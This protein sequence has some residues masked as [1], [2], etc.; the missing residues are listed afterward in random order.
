MIPILS[1]EWVVSFT[2]RLT[3]TSVPGKQYCSILHLTELGDGKNDEYNYRIPMVFLKGEPFFQVSFGSNINSKIEY[4]AKSLP[5]MNQP[6]HYEIH[7]R[8]ISGGKYKYFIMQNGEEI[9]SIINSNT[10]QFYNV[11]AYVSSK[12][13]EP[14]P[15]YVKNVEITNFL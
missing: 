14:C 1:N 9:Y 10:Q 12:W 7:Q 4:V 5:P 11:K 8:Y 13:L 3:G 6:T 2:I 15:A